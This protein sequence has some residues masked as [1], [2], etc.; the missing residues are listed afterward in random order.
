MSMFF[1]QT[2]AVTQMIKVAEVA[3][4]TQIIM[5][6]MMEKTIMMTVMIPTMK[7][8]IMYVPMIAMTTI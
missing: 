1:R 5:L 2:S 7:M 6:M 8:K 4:A 3:I